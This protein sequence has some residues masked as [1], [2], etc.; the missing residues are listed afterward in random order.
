MKKLTVKE[1]K[2]AGCGACVGICPFGAISI[3]DS[4]KATIDDKKCNHCGKCQEICPF[5]AII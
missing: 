5:D 3:N 1:S 2:C 4:G